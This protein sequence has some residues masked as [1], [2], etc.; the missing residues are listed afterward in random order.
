MQCRDC[1]LTSSAAREISRC[2]PFRNGE[3]RIDDVNKPVCFAV[4]GAGLGWYV[5]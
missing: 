2:M 3:A 4:C 1:M 5:T